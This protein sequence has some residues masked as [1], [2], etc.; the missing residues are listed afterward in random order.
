M[1]GSMMQNGMMGGGM[2]NVSQHDMSVYMEMFNRHTEIRRNVE[3][4][5]NGIRTTTESDD[6]AIAA[7]LQEHVPRMWS[8]VDS[9]SE[10]RCMSDSLPTLFRSASKYRRTLQLTSKGVV[11]T[12]TTGDPEVLVALHKHADEVSGFVREGMPVMMRG[13]MQQ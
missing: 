12:E 1:N 10:V 9:G 3:L 8:H 7:L 6:P 5:S 2:M 4:L 11:V 13:M